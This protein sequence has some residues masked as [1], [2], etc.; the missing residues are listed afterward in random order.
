MLGGRSG[1]TYILFD[2]G[3]YDCTMGTCPDRH[4]HMLD[5]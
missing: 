1:D 2:E 4:R 5:D 3:F